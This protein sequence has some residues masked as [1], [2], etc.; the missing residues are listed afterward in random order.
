MY[1]NADSARIK[2]RSKREGKADRRK[3]MRKMK[4]ILSLSKEKIQARRATEMLEFAIVLPFVF[5]MFFGMFDVTRLLTTYTEVAYYSN[6]ALVKEITES[7]G[8]PNLRR[9]AAEAKNDFMKEAIFRGMIDESGTTFTGYPYED[10]RFSVGKRASKL[11]L[12]VCIRANVRV[13]TTAP[14]FKNGV[15]ISK[16]SCTINEAKE[17]NW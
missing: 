8:T 2:E 12:V 3:S 10:Q 4:R 14:I 6:Q 9:A 5:L 13:Q 15:T 17:L 7:S 1:N 11:G 16:T